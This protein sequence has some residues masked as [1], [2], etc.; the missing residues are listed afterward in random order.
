MTRHTHTTHSGVW[1]RTLLLDE[2]VTL[3]GVL[4]DTLVL[5][6]VLLHLLHQTLHLRPRA[7]KAIPRL[8][9]G[10]EHTTGWREFTR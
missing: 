1:L 8:P 10:G 6:R 3:H 7:L 4:A 2:Q 9:I 5:V